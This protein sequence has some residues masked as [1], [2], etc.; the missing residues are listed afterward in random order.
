MEFLDLW[1]HKEKQVLSLDQK[2]MMVFLVKMESPENPARTVKMDIPAF[3]GE[4]EILVWL[5]TLEMLV[6]QAKQELREIKVFQ[7]HEV[8]MENLVY[9]ERKVVAV[10]LAHLANKA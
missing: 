4:Q 2:E 10:S 5:E 6:Y 1:D 3:L 9:Q 7:E 8:S